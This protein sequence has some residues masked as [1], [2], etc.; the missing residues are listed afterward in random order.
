VLAE[1]AEEIG[2]TTVNVAEYRGVIAALEQAAELRLPRL[3]VRMDSRLVVQ[4]LLGL[5]T[6]RSPHLCRLHERALEAASRFELVAYR[7]VPREQNAVADAM[8]GRLLA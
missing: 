7:W 3:E 2:V 5:W 8:V 1:H 6:V 4:Q